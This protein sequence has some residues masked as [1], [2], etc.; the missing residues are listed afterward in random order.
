MLGRLCGPSERKLCIVCSFKPTSEPSLSRFARYGR[1]YRWSNLK[2]RFRIRADRLG[3]NQIVFIGGARIPSSANWKIE[4]DSVHRASR[5]GTKG[6]A[7]PSSSDFFL[8]ASFLPLLWIQTLVGCAPPSKPL[9]IFFHQESWPL[10]LCPYTFSFQLQ[11]PALFGHWLLWL[12]GRVGTRFGG[13]LW[14][15]RIGGMPF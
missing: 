8:R 10:S 13:D 5:M 14:S 4:A 6:W 7:I 12:F 15:W 11:I 2:F 1:W 3:P 9:A